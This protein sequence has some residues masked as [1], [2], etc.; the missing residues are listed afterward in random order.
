MKR[1][2]E[3]DL[4]KKA[5]LMKILEADKFAADS[6]ERIGYKLR[7]GA[8]LGE[9]KSKLYVYISS[10]EENIKKADQKIKAISTV[11]TGDKEKKVLDKIAA[12]EEGAETGF[13]SLF[14]E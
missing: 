9:D 10:S 14:G 2:Y 12:E 5:E 11:L 3:C 1:V 13:G 7:E 6:F 4:S 8:S